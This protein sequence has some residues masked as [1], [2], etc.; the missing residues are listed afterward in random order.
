MIALAAAGNFKSVCYPIRVLRVNK[1]AI[2]P[3]KIVKAMQ[4]LPV[5]LKTGQMSFQKQAV[6]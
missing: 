5:V 3:Y 2:A 1:K 6:V 4:R